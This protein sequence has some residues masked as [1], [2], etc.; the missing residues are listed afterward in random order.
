MGTG[1]LT[2]YEEDGMGLIGQHDYAVLSL[3]E[4]GRQR[5][6]LIKNPWS[7]G[8][9]WK[10]SAYYGSSSLALDRQQTT[11][12]DAVRTE[13]PDP[14]LPGTFWMDLNDVFQSFESIYLNWNPALFPHREDSHF[15]WNL[16]ASIS[17]AGSFV[18]NP[19]YEVR[20]KSGGT[21]WLLLSRHFKSRKQYR[22]NDIEKEVQDEPEESGF[23]G[24][25][26]YA[27]QGERVVLS[28]GALMRGPYVDSPNTLVKLDMPCNTAYTV[29][30][31]E[32]DLARSV[33]HF[34]LS[35]F[36]ISPVI[37][38][39]AIE[40]YPHV[41]SQC[42]TWTYSSAGGN[43]SSSI[44]HTNPQ[45]RIQ[46]QETSDISLLLES[47]NANYAVHVNLVWSQ[48]KGVTS[49]KSRDV[50]GDS[51]EYRNG[52][53]FAEMANVD[54]GTYT[55]VCSTFES[56]Q[57]GRFSLRVA[58]L[59]KVVLH[60]VPAREAG[61]LVS[62]LDLAFF[63]RES[64]RL[65]APL[66]LRR[67]TRLCMTAKSNHNSTS[68]GPRSRSPIKLSLEY[69]Q[70]PT[71]QVLSVSG[72]DEFRDGQSGVRTEDVDLQPRMCGQ[73]GLWIVIARLG[74]P[75]LQPDDESVE[76]EILSEAP[77]EVGK[78]GVGKG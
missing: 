5:L 16:T 24:L 46:L 78:W 11:R 75:E 38:Q 17:P 7:K 36:S 72:N 18:S 77:V 65:L 73:R 41:V 61:R 27:N 34:T 26:V 45:F 76:I 57:F 3:K 12:G 9:I 64:D 30:V 25:Y 68:L 39:Q 13:K 42:G 69:G 51:G 28:D 59:S 31:S 10:G 58:S 49:I 66:T 8:T 15:A 1:K 19:Q 33:Y 54:A 60:R 14:L 52:Y 35:A 4:V 62:R 6:L 67:V 56:G 23:I 29:V 74:R 63:P 48:G 70:G 37:V 50:V 44:Y 20:S 32:Q 43:A 55:A 47:E 21:V 2:E 53:A 22:R 40:A 71:K